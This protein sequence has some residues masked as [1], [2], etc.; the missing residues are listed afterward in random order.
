MRPAVARYKASPKN[1]GVSMVT[2]KEAAIEAA[3]RPG[4]M[5]VGDWTV[6]SGPTLESGAYLIT[7]SP[8]TPAP[9]LRLGFDARSPGGAL[10]GGCR[11]LRGSPQHSEPTLR[12]FYHSGWPGGPSSS[13]PQPIPPLESCLQTE[14]PSFLFPTGL[15]QGRALTPWEFRASAKNLVPPASTVGFWP[16]TDLPW[17]HTENCH[18][19]RSPDEPYLQSLSATL[20]GW[21]LYSYFMEE[22]AE[23]QTGQMRK[24]G[25]STAS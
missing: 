5:D 11:G 7:P 13:P 8:L 23:G 21:N 2:D 4:N 22:E 19:C 9:D 14:A 15:P 3:G 25:S 6:P 16:L 1:F 17:P 24:S 18:R 12:K 10:R 20:Q